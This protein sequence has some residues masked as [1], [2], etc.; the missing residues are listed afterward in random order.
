[1]KTVIISASHTTDRLPCETGCL[2]VMAGASLLQIP[3]PADR[4]RDDTGNNISVKNREYCELTALYW[5]W[6][7]LDADNL[8]LCHYRRYFESALQKGNFLLPDEAEYLLDCFDVLLPLER[9]YIFETNHTQYCNAHNEADLDMT[10]RIIM[11][12]YPGYIEAF[13]RRMSMTKGHRFNMFIMKKALADEY[14]E[15]LFDILSELE[16]RLDITGYTGK[17]R[18]VFGLVAERLLDVWID[19]K[20]LH[21]TDLGYIFIGKEHLAYKAV[22][23]TIRKL[24]AL[25]RVKLKSIR[26]IQ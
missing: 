16:K 20:R 9:D 2:P 6:K 15:W 4:L 11:E 21:T 8:G 5:A 1:M 17:D 12:K 26:K 25:L 7:N 22:A 19:E 18:R 23:M 14:C 24:R 13:D 3:I 10:R